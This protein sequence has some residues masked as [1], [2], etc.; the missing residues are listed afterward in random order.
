MALNSVQK[1]LA[2][3][4]A[5]YIKS[6]YRTSS[7]EFKGH[8]VIDSLVSEKSLFFITFWHGHLAMLPCAWWWEKPFYML[9]SQHR[10]GQLISRVLEHFNIQSVFGS[11]TRGGMVAGLQILDLI[12]TGA[13]IG[14][15][16][17]GPRGP[18]QICSMGVLTLAKL[19]ATEEKPIHIVP[20]G[21]F[22]QRHKRLRSWDK[23][24]FPLPFSKGFFHAAEAIT[25]TPHDDAETL[26]DKRLELQ[27]RLNKVSEVEGQILS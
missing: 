16:P 24:L 1:T 9:L 3:L 22:I 13:V 21:Y 11:T 6:V 8:R 17:D 10:D 14:V 18:H 27:K 20:V 2:F 25:I 23:F 7:F 12:K 19:A 5:L 4:I 15:T 26:E